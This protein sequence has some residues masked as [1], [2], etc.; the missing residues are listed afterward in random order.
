MSNKGLSQIPK[1]R[2]KSNKG[3]TIQRFFSNP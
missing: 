1:N 2:F 3:F